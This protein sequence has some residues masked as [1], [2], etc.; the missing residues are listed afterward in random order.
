M[1]LATTEHSPAHDGSGLEQLERRY[2]L[3][4][5]LGHHNRAN[6]SLQQEKDLRGCLIQT[7]DWLAEIKPQQLALNRQGLKQL[8]RLI[9]QKRERSQQIKNLITICH[10]YRACGKAGG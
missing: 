1:V 7:T 6:S 5:A 3:G 2:A 10:G 9:G 8:F 4:E